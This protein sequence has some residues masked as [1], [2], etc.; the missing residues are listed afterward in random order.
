MHINIIA[1]TNEVGLDSDANLLQTTL[2]SADHKVTFSHCRGKSL[3]SSL[4]GKIIKKKPDFDANIF[5]E[6]TFSAWFDSAPI[7][8]LIPNQERYPERQLNKLNRIDHIFCKSKHALKIFSKYSEVYKFQTHL[9]SFTSKDVHVN[10]EIP[11]YG[12]FFHLAGRSTLKGTDTILK[13]W[14]KNP[15]WP[16]LTIVQNKDNAPEKESLPSN[17]TLIAEHLPYGELIK[18]SNKSGIH[19]CTSLSEGWGHYIVEAMSAK[20]VVITTD[21]P[22]MNELITPDR[23]IL[24][25]HDKSEPR[26]LGTNFYVNERALEQAINDVI[27]LDPT[28]KEATGLASRAW[29]L[30]NHQQFTKNIAV[31]FTSISSPEVKIDSQ[32]IVLTETTEHSNQK[33]N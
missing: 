21:A 17:V 16:L 10:D 23:G 24:I 5:L 19:L 9:T 22:P 25:P 26:H 28:E 14:V 33:V 8:I 6:R 29:F 18:L 20:A 2:E 15:Q 7:N 31:S 27:A 13:L 30:R 4:L 12:K 11:N 32:A 1:R 3:V